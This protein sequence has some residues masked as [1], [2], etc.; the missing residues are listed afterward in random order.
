MLEPSAGEG[1]L[2]AAA[3]AV[4]PS[5]RIRAVEV[6]ADRLA[7]LRARHPQ[8]ACVQA[9]FLNTPPA[10]VYDLVLMNPPFGGTHWLDHIQH[11]WEFVA[12]GGTLAAILPASAEVSE[13]PMH[14]R[15]REWADIQG[16]HGWDRKANWQPLPEGSFESSGT[17]IN[18]VMFRMRRA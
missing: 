7:V 17:N 4:D 18:T 8:V 11:A 6:H 15:F 13:S 5:V 2:V 1:A 12:P 3:L 16:G 9:N 14:E 10:P